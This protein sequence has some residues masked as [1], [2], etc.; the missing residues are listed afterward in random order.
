MTCRIC[1]SAVI[2]AFSAP[3]M[4]LGLRDE[5]RYCICPGCGSI[6]I[7]TIPQDLDRYY[8]ERA[9]YS[10]QGGEWSDRRGWLRA[11]LGNRLD[12]AQIFSEG[13]LMGLLARRRQSDVAERLRTYIG[14]SPVRS[15]NARILDV[16]CGSGA[17]VR[18]LA[19]H[20][21]ARAEGI[22]PHVPSALITTG[23][24]PRLRRAG[25]PDVLGERFDMVLLTHVLEHA[26]DPHATMR[27]IAVIL[28]PGG[29]CRVEVPVAD[30]EAC[31]VY[32]K[33]WVELD[34]PRHL[35]IPTRQALTLL[36]EAAGLEIYRR[37]P[38]GSGFE[39]WGSEMY[40]RGLSL[41]DRDNQR[42]RTPDEVFSDG[43]LQ[44]FQERA[45]AAAARGESGRER[46]YLRL[47]TG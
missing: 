2:D 38:A 45:A 14:E 33:N 13:G 40:C 35:Q 24:A 16:G 15:W 23:G 22:D 3:E 34:A 7:A 26:D 44:H 41:F 47:A 39:F 19:M 11:W 17:L 12:R 6:Q 21:F 9:Y 30:S 37:E 29:A 20:G 42:Y 43:E 27:M 8:D 18:E 1:G 46:L 32:G 25:L 4:M 28:S 36:A 31:R 10:L 5:Y